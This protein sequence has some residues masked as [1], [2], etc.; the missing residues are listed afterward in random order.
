M[1]TC[2]DHAYELEEVWYPGVAGCESLRQLACS[3]DTEALH[4]MMQQCAFCTCQL[5]DHDAVPQLLQSMV[6]Q[7]PETSPLR[8]LA[9]GQHLRMFLSALY[10]NRS[11]VRSLNTPLLGMEYAC[12]TCRFQGALTSTDLLAA[13][14]L[15]AASPQCCLRRCWLSRNE[16]C[17]SLICCRCDALFNPIASCKGTWIV[18][19]SALSVLHLPCQLQIMLQQSMKASLDAWQTSKRTSR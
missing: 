19:G 3:E 13:S 6:L 14:S 4:K 11:T 12:S 15:C 17:S 10:S 1:H 8:H 2:S 9:T 7:A 16:C 18:S 5:I